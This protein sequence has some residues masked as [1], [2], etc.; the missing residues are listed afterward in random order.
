M[1]TIED[2]EIIRDPNRVDPVMVMIMD[3]ED[4][5]ATTTRK[6]NLT[7]DKMFTTA[8]EAIAITTTAATTAVTIEMLAVIT[9]AT[10]SLTVAPT[11][12]ETLRA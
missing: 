11:A 4:K 7:A 3:I 1:I 9:A 12:R 10:M 2:L 6:A 5:T 8:K